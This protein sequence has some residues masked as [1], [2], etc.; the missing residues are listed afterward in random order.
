MFA[1]ATRAPHE[2][3]SAERGGAERGGAG[4]EAQKGALKVGIPNNLPRKKKEKEKS[5]QVIIYVQHAIKM[6][7][8]SYIYHEI[9][10]V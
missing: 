9:V 10:P 8:N 5:E 7:L 2:R 6:Q 3:T 4:G 1:G